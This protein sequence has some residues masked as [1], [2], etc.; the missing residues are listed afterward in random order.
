MGS[1]AVVLLNVLGFFDSLRQLIKQGVEEGFIQSYNE[2]LIIF[3]D[4]P[5]SLQEHEKYDWGKAALGALD[6]W[7]RDTKPLFN[8]TI[9]PTGTD[10]GA[11]DPLEAS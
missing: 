11:H 10:E 8:W 2:N 1:I 3:V 6:N 7:A 9:S 5:E 4:G